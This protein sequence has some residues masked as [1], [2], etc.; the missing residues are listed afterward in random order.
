MSLLRSRFGR[1]PLTHAAVDRCADVLHLEAR[2]LADRRVA[3]VTANNQRGAD[4]ER[5]V[6]GLGLQTDNV[7]PL[8]QGWGLAVEWPQDGGRDWT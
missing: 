1:T 8:R 4:R 3:A 7:A 5:P 2:P 6:R